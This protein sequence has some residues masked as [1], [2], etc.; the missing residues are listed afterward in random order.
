MFY[1]KSSK[2][3]IIWVYAEMNIVD[4]FGVFLLT[5]P[6]L[7]VLCF[8]SPSCVTN[9]ITICDVRLIKSKIAENKVGW[10]SVPM[11]LGI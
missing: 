11:S 4:Y 3:L 2:R 1:R 5:I 7:F 10:L 6:I 9:V 8:I